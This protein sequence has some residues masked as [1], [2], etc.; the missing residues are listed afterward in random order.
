MPRV[1][2]ES[3]WRTKNLNGT[4]RRV[5]GNRGWRDDRRRTESL[6]HGPQRGVHRELAVR[7]AAGRRRYGGSRSRCRAAGCDSRATCRPQGPGHAWCGP[8]LG[9]LPGV[10]RPRPGIGQAT[11][12]SETALP[13]RGPRDMSLLGC[14][15]DVGGRIT[16]F[17]DC[18]LQCHDHV[19]D[20]AEATC[21]SASETAVYGRDARPVTGVTP[22]ATRIV[23]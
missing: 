6:A 16:S 18:K 15:T 10:L 13:V 4:Y 11:R 21:A 5:K 9:P 8:H 22:L 3:L 14:E 7:E 1:W 20:Y 17:S 23:R 19:S 2:S 12:A